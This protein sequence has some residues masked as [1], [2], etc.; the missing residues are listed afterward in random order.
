LSTYLI[1]FGAAVRADG[2]PS[3]SLVRR[4]QGALAFAPMVAGPKY[5]VTGGVGR[6][7]PAE[8]C[9]MQEMLIRDG[10]KPEDI[11]VEDK[12]RDTLES[13]RF[14][15]VILRTRSDVDQVVPCT[16]RYHLPRCALLLRMLGYKVRVPEMPADR[17]D[18]PLK[19]WLFF[20]LKEVLALPYDALLMIPALWSVRH[21]K[22]KA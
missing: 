11:T 21:R 2:T 18:L 14:C 7:G 17:P 10:V 16:S 5:V 12:A 6:Y 1:I 9:V 3:G 15:D 19:K 4:V 22:R 13:V 8:A 20:L